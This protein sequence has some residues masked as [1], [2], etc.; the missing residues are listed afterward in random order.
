MSH[1]IIEGIDR[2]FTPKGEF[3]ATWHGLQSEIDGQLTRENCA[4]VFCPIVSCGIKPDFSAE[5]A[6]VPEE[7]QAEM[8]LSD[9]KMILADC[10][11]GLSGNV[12]PLYIPKKGYKIHQNG[13]LFDCMITAAKTVLGDNG[14]E[15][16]T[17]GTLGGYSQFFVSIAIKGQETFE[18]G[19]L[20]N[21][22]SDIWKQF[23][24]LNSSHNGLIASN[25]ML[26]AV[27]MVCMNTVQM[28]I[29]DAEQA[30]SISA[31]KHT[32][33]SGELVTPEQFAKDLENWVNNGKA[34]QANLARLKEIKMNVE[35]FKSF[36]AGVFTNEASDFLSTNSFN[37]IDEMS[38]MFEKGIGNEG[39]TRYCGLQA[40]TEFF[41]SGNGAGNPATV[42]KSKR[43]ATANFGRGNDWKLQAMNSLFNVG[44]YN[45]TVSRGRVLYSDKAELVAAGN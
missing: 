2:V 18:V 15:V 34:F 27:R 24:N 12:I 10:R 16:V 13:E 21:G 26:S 42:S 23:F 19:K 35:Q 39:K 7:L 20:A 36:A 1:L 6:D 22:A 11:K 3:A 40:F 41:T 25:R 30:G 37:R 45:K 33:N 29:M 9:W 38:A 4:D 31:I 5:V 28:S 43:V 17:L 32:Q 44:E 8:N 14:F